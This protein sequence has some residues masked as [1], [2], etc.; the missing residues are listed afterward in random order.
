MF[1]TLKIQGQGHG[2]GQSQNVGLTSYRLTTLSFHLN[3]PSL[4][5]DIA[6]SKFDLENPRSRWLV[7]AEG[8]IVGTTPYQL[9]ASDQ[10][11]IPIYSFSKIW[12]WKSKV[13]VMV[14]VN[15]ESHNMDPTFYQLTSLS[16]HVNRLSHSYDTAVSKF[17]LENPRSRSWMRWMLKI[18]TSV[19]HSIY[20]HPFHS[21]S[22]GHP[23]PE[24]RLF[25]N[26]TLKIQGHG[27]GHGWG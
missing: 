16:F 17:D 10:C 23:I 20:S 27:H 25:L 1:F 26:L 3:G 4:S 21:M 11:H 15:V 19:Q 9:I 5:W 8:H 14:E 7:I 13:M 6:F 12:P 22:I 18:T 24:I 2:W